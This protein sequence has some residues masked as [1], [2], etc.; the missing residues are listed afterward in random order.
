MPL[1]NI[2]STFSLCSV[3]FVGASGYSYISPVFMARYRLRLSLMGLLLS[4]L[5]IK[6]LS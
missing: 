1:M 3:R 6:E 2:A 4:E 5:A